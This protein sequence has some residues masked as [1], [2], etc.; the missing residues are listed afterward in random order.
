MAAA[1][2]ASRFAIDDI[3]PARVTRDDVFLIVA[4]NRSAAPGPWLPAPDWALCQR[5]LREQCDVAIDFE[6]VADSL[7]FD[8]CVVSIRASGDRGGT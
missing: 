4:S 1:E 2:A 3:H 8:A 5:T 7:A 6:R